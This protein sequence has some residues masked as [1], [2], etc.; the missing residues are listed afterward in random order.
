MKTAF[1]CGKPPPQNF[2]LPTRGF[3]LTAAFP[4]QW[5]ELMQRGN[6]ARSR[7]KSGSVPI[8][9]MPGSGTGAAILSSSL[10]DAAASP[11]TQSPAGT[12][13]LAERR[14]RAETKCPPLSAL[15]LCR[16]RRAAHRKALWLDAAGEGR[17]GE[18]RG[19]TEQDPLQNTA[20]ASAMDPLPWIWRK[21]SSALATPEATVTLTAS[22]TLAQR[23]WQAQEPGQKRA[24]RSTSSA[25]C[26]A[27]DKAPRTRGAPHK[28]IAA[29]GAAASAVHRLQESLRPR[30]E[31]GQTGQPP[32]GLPELPKAA[33]E[34]RRNARAYSSSSLYLTRSP[35]WKGT[36]KSSSPLSCSSSRTAQA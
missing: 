16:L 36:Q 12:S 15:R 29:K 18:R 34:R 20:P 35:S 31:A 2:C 11:G 30:P 7:I 8:L 13:L 3:S 33:G 4:R 1:S 19:G 10:P 28:R 23:P 22:Q 32:D 17:G 5:C 25:D 27:K 14:G 21:E 26:T 9:G 24:R 6:M